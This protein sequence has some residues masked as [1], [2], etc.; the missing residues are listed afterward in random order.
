MKYLFL[1]LMFILS[2]TQT[3]AQRVWTFTGSDTI[4]NTA[5]VTLKLPVKDGYN[6]AVFQVKNVRL[7]GTNAGTSILQGSNEDVD[8]TYIPIDTITH[9]NAAT[10]S[11]AF[12]IVPKFA[13][14]RIIRTGSGTMS[15]ITSATGHFKKY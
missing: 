14:Y 13:F 12:E 11:K 7:S 1:I 3:E 4:A 2:F 9:T 6:S 5:S 8:A 10:E 15:V